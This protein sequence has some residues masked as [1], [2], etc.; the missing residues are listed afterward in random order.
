MVLVEGNLGAGRWAPPLTGHPPF[1][2][3]LGLRGRG[4]SGE[5]EGPWMLT[6]AH[7]PLQS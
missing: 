7:F 1:G 2:I 5:G 4:G 6:C 3:R